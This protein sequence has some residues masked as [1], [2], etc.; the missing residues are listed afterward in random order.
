MPTLDSLLEPIVP[1]TRLGSR[2]NEVE[3][4]VNRSGSHGFARG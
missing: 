3:T 4:R 2:S 1:D